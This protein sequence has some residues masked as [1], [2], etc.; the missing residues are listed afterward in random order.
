MPPIK[1][2]IF[3]LIDGARPD[4]L[5]KLADNGSLPNIQRHLILPYHTV[6]DLIKISESELDGCIPWRSSYHWDPLV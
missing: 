6:C 3:Y 2:V 5:K 1:K 4:I